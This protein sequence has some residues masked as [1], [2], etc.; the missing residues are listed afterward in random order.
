M[1]DGIGSSGGKPVF[2]PKSVVGDVVLVHINQETSEFKRGEIIDILES[3]QHRRGAPCPYFSV[4]GGCSLQHMQDSYYREFKIRIVQNALRQ[5]G[6]ETAV[7][8]AIFLPES[9]RRRVEFK[10]LNENNKFFLAY[11]GNRSHTKIAISNCL[12]LET[13][14]QKLLPLLQSCL[15][16]LSF[17]DAVESVSI[18]HIDS[19]IEIIF[20]LKKNIIPNERLDNEI[21]ALANKL[22]LNRVIVVDGNENPIAIAENKK[23]TMAL[24]SIEI[25]LPINSFL[26]ATK[27]GQRLLTEF[28]VAETKGKKHILDLFCGIGTYSFSLAENAKVEAVDSGKDMIENLNSTSKNYNCSLTAMVRNL[29]TMPFTTNELDKFDTVVLNPPRL[30]AK[31]QCEQ[32]ALSRIDKVVMVSCNPATFVRDAKI[33]KTSG[34]NLKNIIAIDQFIW[35]PH[36]EIAA[37]F[38]RG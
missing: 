14:L 15:G 4:C 10:L 5:I 34:F 3:G 29:F 24:G 28:V 35:S 23:F 21:K 9:S 25:N 1:G 22:N 8:P 26:Q 37:S 36:L 19:G 17:A 32:I 6:F 27:E 18:C 16:D 30:G 12:I 33:L 38:V 31:A 2:V 7:I 13:D 20:S 11:L